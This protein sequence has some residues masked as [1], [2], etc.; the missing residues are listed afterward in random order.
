MKS[1]LVFATAGLLFASLAFAQTTAQR[2]ADAGARGDHGPRQHGQRGAEA[3]AASDSNRDGKL[4]LAEFES[5]RSRRIA[6]HFQAMD[7]NRDGILTQDEMHQAMRQHR[8]LRASRRHGRMAMREGLRALDAD[9]DKALTRAEIGDKAPRLAEN[10][11]AFDLD[12][13]GRLT[14]DEMRAGRK[15]LHRA[16]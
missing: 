9:G 13:D 8:D 1:T 14:R 5:A 4:S 7:A 12:N 6:E 16:R 2:Q 10:F 15:A 3:F 11:A